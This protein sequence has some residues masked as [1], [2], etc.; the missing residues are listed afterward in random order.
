M[1]REQETT[2]RGTMYLC[3][4]ARP[5]KPGYS[6]GAGNETQVVG[7]RRRQENPTKSRRCML[8]RYALPWSGLFW[9]GSVDGYGTVA[10]PL[11]P[12]LLS[13]LIPAAVCLHPPSPP[14]RDTKRPCPSFPEYLLGQ[15]AVGKTSEAWREE[16]QCLVS[17]VG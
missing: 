7:S 12:L 13:C 4:Q 9:T 6:L 14:P 1:R 10:S 8:R 15:S 2:G 11:S 17:W 5:A 3:L 16:R